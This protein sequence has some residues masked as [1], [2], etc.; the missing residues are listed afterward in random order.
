MVRRSISLLL[1]LGVVANQLASIPH[2]HDTHG[3]NEH[4]AR[5]HVHLAWFWHGHDHADHR[6]EHSG[7]QACGGSVRHDNDHDADAIYLAISFG[8]TRAAANDF[9][10]VRIAPIA[11]L[12]VALPSCLPF[13]DRSTAAW[14]ELH[15]LRAPDCA[16]YLALRALRI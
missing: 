12:S 3:A 14:A 13:G 6:H 10:A 9:G 8:L 15:P 7:P 4:D 1:L 11:A 16:L 5:P 2:G